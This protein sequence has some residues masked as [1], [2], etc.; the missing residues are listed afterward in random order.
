E[1]YQAKANDYIKLLNKNKDR[2]RSTIG[3][4]LGLTR[5][6]EF[7]LLGKRT[8]FNQVTH[9][10][11]QQSFKGIPVWGMQTNVGIGPDNNVV[12]LHGTIILDTPRDIAGIP[13]SLD[14]QGALKRMKEL[15]KKKDKGAQWH[16]RNEEYGTYIYIDKK[17]KA[18]LCY[19][20]S[21][22][23]DTE[24]GNPSQFIHFIDVKTGKALHSFDMLNYA[25]GTG[26][27][28]NLKTGYY[29]YGIDYPGF[30]VTE[31]AGICTMDCPEVRT[32]DLNHGTTGTTP[33]S[34]TCYE[35]THEEINGAYCPMNDA[36]FFGQVTYD[37]YND[38]YG[39]PPVP[40]QLTIKCHYNT[41][42]EA[43]F[44]DGT[45]VILGDGYTTFY[46]LGSLDVISHEFSHGFTQNN[47]DLIYSSQSG[48]I[49]ESFSDSAGE[50]AEYYLRG[51]C[52][53]MCG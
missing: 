14:P 10:R 22:F 30:C 32:I 18:H 39:V 44:W 25:Q 46:P 31:A 45:N 35:N 28:G 20:V 3:K 42:Y 6:E 21:F 33:Y 51:A 26:P 8:D 43:A 41:N 2:E 36:Q 19:V 13:A 5:D 9:Y 48:G 34:Y 17:G 47:S 27:G 50:A 40:F 12:R 53:Y 1:F 7:K 15:H 52:D 23:A 4:T 49:N 37:M 29:Y 38:W 11:Y 24:K 16:F